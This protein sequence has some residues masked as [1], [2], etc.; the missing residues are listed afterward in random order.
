LRAGIGTV[1]DL[2]RAND[3]GVQSVRI[4]THC[5]DA[6]ISAQHITTAREL[7]M[8]VSGFL[9]MSHMSPAADF[10][11]QAKLMESYGAPGA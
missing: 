9:M 8:D 6:D 1:A 2:R 3:L 5:T 4:T 11:G 10:A 7:G